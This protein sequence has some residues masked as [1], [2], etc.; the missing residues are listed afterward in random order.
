MLLRCNARQR[1]SLITWLDMGILL[2]LRKQGCKAVTC[3]L[4]KT[5]IYLL[6]ARNSACLIPLFPL[7]RQP[8]LLP[9]HLKKK[10]KDPHT[11]Y[12]HPAH[13]P[14]QPGDATM[15]ACIL[16]TATLRRYAERTKRDK[17]MVA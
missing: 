7:L 3:K 12:T 9:L 11:L 1:A 5:R 13:T 17:L 8:Q 14:P 6:P 16:T 4:Q 15:R 10:K 2:A